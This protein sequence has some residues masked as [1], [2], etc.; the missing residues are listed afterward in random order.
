[1]HDNHHAHLH[2][3]G[4]AGGDLGPAAFV[5]AADHGLFVAIALLAA[6]FVAVFYVPKHARAHH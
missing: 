6:A 2:R 4:T 5:G 3:S 1:M